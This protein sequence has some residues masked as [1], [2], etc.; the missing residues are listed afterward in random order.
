MSG[1]RRCDT[2]NPHKPALRLGTPSGRT[3]VANF[4]TGT[5]RCAG[6][7]RNGCRVIVRFNLE[8][9]MR[10]LV[11]GGVVDANRT[12]RVTSSG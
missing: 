1:M 2:E 3:L 7:R 6:E 5:R 12:F 9:G 4:S 10:Q 11:A 8:Y